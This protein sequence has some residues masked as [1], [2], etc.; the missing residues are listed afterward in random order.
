MLGRVDDEGI[1]I[2]DGAVEHPRGGA[3]QAVPESETI[4]GG[5]R[6]SGGIRGCFE[7]AAGVST[8]HGE[9]EGSG[10]STLVSAQV[11]CA[12]GVYAQE[13]KAVEVR[14]PA[15]NAQACEKEDA[16]GEGK[17]YDE[18]R[19]VVFIVHCVVCV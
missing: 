15:Q 18:G 12:G 2:R 6:G 7:C 9:R 3:P 17:G 19:V 10:R 11:E 1:A 4:N 16:E 14:G 8:V 5:A 13:T